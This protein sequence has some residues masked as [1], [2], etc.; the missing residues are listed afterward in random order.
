MEFW[1]EVRRCG[2][3]KRELDDWKLFRPDDW[4][5]SKNVIRGLIRWERAARSIERLKGIADTAANLPEEKFLWSFA[6]YERISVLKI[7]ALGRFVDRYYAYAIFFLGVVWCCCSHVENMKRAIVWCAINLKANCRAVKN[8]Q[9]QLVM[10][11]TY[12][13]LSTIFV[14]RR[15]TMLRCLPSLNSGVTLKLCRLS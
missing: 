5:R 6:S 11:T 3:S 15:V 8:T 10:F 12:W 13:I 2:G 1:A 14:L 9:L 7:N 4:R